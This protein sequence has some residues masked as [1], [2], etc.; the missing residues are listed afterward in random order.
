MKLF[1]IFG[2][3][4]HRILAEDHHVDGKVTKRTRTVPQIKTKPVRLYATEQNTI[5][6]HFLSFDYTVNDIVYHGTLYVHLHCRCPQ[7]GESITVY[8]D[9][10]KPQNYDCYPFGPRNTL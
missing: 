4:A 2:I 5:C 1:R 7:N 6:S 8:Y 10:E 3:G 9:P